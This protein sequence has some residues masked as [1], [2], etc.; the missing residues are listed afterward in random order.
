MEKVVLYGIGPLA[1]TAYYLYKCIKKTEVVAFMADDQF[2]S[3]ET[4]FGLPILKSSLLKNNPNIV[5]DCKFLLCIGYKSM[6]NRKILFERLKESGCQ[7]T[8]LIPDSVIIQP[9]VKIGV[10]NIMNSSVIIE[11]S[12][13]IGDNNVF[14]T[15]CAV[16]HNARVGN[17]NYFSGRAVVSGNCVVG[18]LCFMGNNS[19]MIDGISIADETMIV[20]GSGLFEN[21]VPHSR[22]FGHPARV[23]GKHE[24]TGIMI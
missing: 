10:N 23:V 5:E 14:W 7:F 15:R 9:N 6:R 24:E 3:A 18:D 21:S 20:A 8:N 12:A 2:V 19:Y 16:A 4:K 17:H 11:H 22:Y 1:E 13:V